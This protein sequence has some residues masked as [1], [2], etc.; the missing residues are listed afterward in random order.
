[1]ELQSTIVILSCFLAGVI[2]LVL[3]IKLIERYHRTQKIGALFLGLTAVSLAAGNLVWTIEDTFFDGTPA[4]GK[5]AWITITVLPVYF[6]VT[7]SFS[8]IGIKNKFLRGISIFVA[9]L[10]VVSFAMCPLSE[11]ELDG[12]LAYAP[13]P[14]TKLVLIPVAIMGFVPIFLWGMYAGEMARAG[15]RI[16][17]DRG[18]VLAAGFL[19]TL[20]GENILFT[21]TKT[22]MPICCAMSLV[23]VIM[24]YVAFTRTKI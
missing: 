2:S 24:L 18:I 11:I 7:F 4:L 5:L 16:E 10:G 22:P 21:H 15:R 23:G 13:N 1:M 3:S 17:R 6:S 14:I 20:L 12:I 19:V 8:S 9:L